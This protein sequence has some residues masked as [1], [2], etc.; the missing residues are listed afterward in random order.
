MTGTSLTQ[1]LEIDVSR[2]WRERTRAVLLGYVLLGLLAQAY[3][4]AYGHSFNG[5]QGV[6]VAFASVGTIHQGGALLGFA[7]DAF[8]AWRVWRGGS[9]SFTILLFL[10]TLIA[11][12][13]V[14]ATAIAG[15]SVYL[16]GLLAFSLA[17]LA[18]IT[19]PAAR[20]RLGVKAL[21]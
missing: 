9:I 11:V 19:S 17:G 12:L 20:R 21:H 1:G 4:H 14:A 6:E 16:A 13:G 3:V 7:I 2:F 18:L 8:L 15:G 10:S 5:G